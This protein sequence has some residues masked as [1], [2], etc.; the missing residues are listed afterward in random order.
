MTLIFK[1]AFTLKCL[2]PSPVEVE[3]CF[4][5]RDSDDFIKI[6]GLTRIV[7]GG[8]VAPKLTTSRAAMHNH[9]AFFPRVF[10]CDRLEQT[11]T[12]AGSVTWV[13]VHMNRMQTF[14]AVVANRT[15]LER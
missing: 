12:I 11:A 10:H 13:H 5:A 6:I 15:I 8:F 4:F 2:H 1:A 9:P 7:Q 14:W 3:L